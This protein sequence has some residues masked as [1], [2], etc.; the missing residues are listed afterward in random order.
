[1]KSVT[2]SM[3]EGQHQDLYRH[4]FPGDGLEAVSLLL[5]GRRAGKR[6]RLAVR[7]LI[8]IPYDECQRATD[9]VTWSTSRLPEL[10]ERVGRR[11]WSLLKVHGHGTLRDF[12]LVDDVSD[13]ELLPSL[14]AWL[15]GGQPLGSLVMMEDG[16]LIGRTYSTDGCFERIE[17]VAVVGN[18]ITIWRDFCSE[19]QI[20]AFGERVAQSFGRGT[21]DLLRALKVGVVGASGTGSPVVEMLARNCVGSLVLVDPDHIEERNLNRIVNA[22]MADARE[23]TSKVAVLERAVKAMGLRTRVETY[24]STLFDRKVVAALADCDVLF[25]CMDSVD[26]R[27]LLNRLASFHCIPYLDLGVRLDAD[28]QGG[29]DQV[30]GSVHYLK[31]GGSSLLSRHVYSTEQL[32]AAG[33]KRTDPTAYRNLLEEGYIKGVAEDRPAVIQ[34]NM[35]IASLAV[36]EL[37]ARLHPYRIDPNGDFAVRRISLSHSIFEAEGDGEP[38]PSLAKHVGR[39]DVEP[40][41]EWAELSRQTT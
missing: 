12:S 4:L 17:R 13:R 10:L 23:S 2:L 37:L 16:E 11:D 19:V 33:L 35:M 26:G 30:C 1:M 5:C 28:G 27:H 22:T 15:D 34:L 31:P 14:D 32:R 9:R 36:N 41:L 3:T 18:D 40:P 39:G 7:E 8:H 29:V 6:E 20:P 24:A 21:F 25:G 38:C